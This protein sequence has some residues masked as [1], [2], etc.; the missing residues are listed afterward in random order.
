MV[1]DVPDLT[2]AG[3]E[4]LTTL[5]NGPLRLREILAAI[6]AKSDTEGGQG[7][8]TRNISESALRK[9]L[10]LLIS[11]GIIARTGSE[12]INPYYFIRRQWLFNYYIMTKCRDGPD[13]DLL[14]L[15]ILLHD[16]S[17]QNKEGMI[18]LPHPHFIAAFGE[19]TE[20]G[21]QVAAEYASF[22]KHLGNSAAIDNYL[23]GIY[24]DIYD[25]RVPASDIDSQLARDFL[26]FVVVAPQEESEVRFFIWYAGFFHTL[27]LNEEA[28]ETFDKG[29]ELA[30]KGGLDIKG[31]LDGARI[32]RGTILLYLNELSGAKQT[33]LDQYITGSGSP[34]SK[35]KNL[36]W[37]GQVELI[38]GDEVLSS[39]IGRFSLAR[40]HCQE[41]DPEGTDMDVQ[42][43]DGDILRMTGSAHRIAGR[44]SDAAAS[45]EAAE[46]IYRN[47]EMFRGLARLLPEQAELL[48]AQ[49]FSSEGP[50][51]AR[52][53][54]EATRKYDEAKAAFQRIRNIRGY[55]HSLIGECELARVAYQK[56]GTPLPADLET[57]YE[58]AFEIYCQI[59]SR[60]GI[61][62]M[63]VSEALLYHNAASQFPDKYADTADKLE[64]AG[65]FCRDL[66]LKAE[67]T[68]IRRIRE[69]SDPSKEL[70]PLLFL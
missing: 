34:F 35:A 1:N 46:K 22:K 49:A 37:T 33:F 17:R 45:Y 14:D 47:G 23:E 24:S 52:Y 56:A 16:I 44:S 18:P 51:Q 70:N 27:D 60:W 62:K 40:K 36:F 28:L 55:A 54:T 7:K 57:K 61:V 6:N 39:V 4:T 69:H 5:Y 32:S 68:L 8:G 50:L 25:N 20:R 12:R 19:R 31:I 9:R 11:Q 26:R 64:Q 30:Q 3:R 10:E 67:L 29:V 2:G 41:A 42:E 15:T 13:P 38:T 53:L 66:G 48:R 65:R 63:F 58:N 43:L 21:Q 59:N